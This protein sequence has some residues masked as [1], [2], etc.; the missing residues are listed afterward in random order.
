VRLKLQRKPRQHLRKD[1]QRSDSKVLGYVVDPLY[2]KLRILR[3]GDAGQ[4]QHA[5]L[6][7]GKNFGPDW[8]E[9]SELISVRLT[10]A[11]LKKAELVG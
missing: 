9:K 4:G 1:T 10:K 5:F 11:G 2:G 7:K 3:I 8:R 6:V